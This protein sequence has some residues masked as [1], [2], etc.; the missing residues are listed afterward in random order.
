MKRENPNSKEDRDESKR[1]EKGPPDSL[2][3]L[4]EFTKRIVKVPK[5]EIENQGHGNNSS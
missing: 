4:R 3:R 2:D 1:P 5:A